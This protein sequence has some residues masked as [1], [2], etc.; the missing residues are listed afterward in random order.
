MTRYCFNCQRFES[1]GYKINKNGYCEDCQ[2]CFCDICGIVES[3]HICK[4]NKPIW[5]T[6]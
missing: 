1:D 2:S 3:N 4:G 5:E 6:Q